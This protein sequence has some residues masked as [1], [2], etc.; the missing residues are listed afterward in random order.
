MSRPTNYRSADRLLLRT[1][2]HGGPWV[3][4]AAIAA[5]ASA[6]GTL[7]LPA[8]LGGALDA[9][10]EHGEAGQWLT[11]CALLVAVLVAAEVL[12]SLTAGAA[13]ARATAWLRHRLWGHVV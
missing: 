3:A 12:D 6:G 5:L 7:A 2:R 10:V 13:T 9:L 1:G 11:W 8:V 4:A